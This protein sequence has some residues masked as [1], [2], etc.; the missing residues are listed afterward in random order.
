MTKKTG[1]IVGPLALA[2]KLFDIGA[3][4]TVYRDL[5]V[6]RARTVLTGVFSADQFRAIEQQK[7]DLAMLPLMIGR[8]VDQSDWPQI[9]ELSER[10][11]A[12]R[13]AVDGKHREVGVARKI[14]VVDDIKL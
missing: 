14:Y 6:L 7:A 3:V 10:A 13:R 5:Y 1:E 4:D 2:S 9:K 11:A 8:A 12:V